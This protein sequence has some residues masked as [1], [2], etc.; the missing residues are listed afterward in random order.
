[1]VPYLQRVEKF[2]PTLSKPHEA[3]HIGQTMSRARHNV[4]RTQRL[5]FG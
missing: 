2:V 5:C 4:I 1:M 3:G